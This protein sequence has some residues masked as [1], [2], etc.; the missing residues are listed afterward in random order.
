VTITSTA[1]GRWR[2][3]ADTTR[4]LGAGMPT[5]ASRELGFET[6]RPS[7]LLEDA[8]QNKGSA[9][10]HRDRPGCRVLDPNQRNRG[11]DG[12][13]PVYGPERPRRWDFVRAFPSVQCATQLP[14]RYY[15]Q[16]S[17][18]WSASASCT[19][20]WKASRSGSLGQRGRAHPRGGSPSLPSLAQRGQQPGRSGR[21]RRGGRCIRH[22]G[23][24]GQGDHRTGGKYLQARSPVVAHRVPNSRTR[25]YGPQRRIAPRP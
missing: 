4:R 7:S 5:L 1:A 24:R 14:G 2:T 12:L 20:A 22:A 18:G 8:R 25:G 21:G 23:Q 6:K 3:S 17:T 19:S 9:R 15:G 11:R 13:I 10:Q 16:C